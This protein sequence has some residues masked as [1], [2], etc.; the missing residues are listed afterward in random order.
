VNLTNDQ[1]TEIAN[2]VTEDP[3]T[4]R[5]GAMFEIVVKNLTHPRFQGMSAALAHYVRRTLRFEKRRY[6]AKETAHGQ[7]PQVKDLADTSSNPLHIVIQ[8]E[9]A[10]ILGNA[11]KSLPEDQQEALAAKQAWPNAPSVAELA[12]SWGRSTTHVYNLANRAVKGLRRTL[13]KQGYEPWPS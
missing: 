10:E 12:D 8:K 1:L 6:E 5:W 2:I 3:K 13:G 9:R 7:M 11:V 4:E